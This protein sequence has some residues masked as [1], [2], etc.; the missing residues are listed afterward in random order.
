MIFTSSEYLLTSE[1]TDFEYKELREY[2]VA[3]IRAPIQKRAELKERYEKLKGIC[4]DAICGPAVTVFHY[5]TPVEGFDAEACYP[6]SHEIKSEEIQCRMLEPISAFTITHHGSYETL[7]D[8]SAKV[9]QYVNSRGLPVWLKPREVYIKGPF[10]DNPEEQVTEI[11]AA[12]HDWEKRFDNALEDV[13]GR[14][15][16]KR[17]IEN[18][19]KV[20]PQSTADERGKWLSGVISNLES[21]AEEEEISEIICRCAHV[22]PEADIETYRKAWEKN[23]DIDDV[24]KA[25]DKAQD[26]VEPPR[27]E[28]NV[29]YVSKIPR[30][31]EAWEK[32]ETLEDKIKAACFCPIVYEMLDKTPRLFCYC[33]GGWAR[34]IFERVLNKPVKVELVKT[35]TKG[36]NV[37]AWKLY[38]PEDVIKK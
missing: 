28:G 3:S 33:G 26:W 31:K 34:Q 36:D 5:D 20:M 6:I 38:L 14:D 18:V 11:Q 9:F 1:T 12:L 35:I 27:R 30:D 2:L 16:K 32:A 25:Y 15:M 23:N 19:D 21:V 37:C 24:I 7:R 22:R 10:L 29:V 13:I 8:S 4:G 17:V